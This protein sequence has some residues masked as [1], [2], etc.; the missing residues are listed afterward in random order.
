[1]NFAEQTTVTSN[2]GP[3]AIP[4]AF[5]QAERLLRPIS[6]SPGGWALWDL[7][8]SPFQVESDQIGARYENQVLRILRI[9]QGLDG[10]QNPEQ[11]KYRFNGTVRYDFTEGRLKGLQVG[12]TARYQDKVSGGYP[13]MLADD[14]VTVLPDIAN[15]W[16]GPDSIDG[17]LF[18]R[19]RKSLTDK[20]DWTIQLN[21]RNLY[22][23]NGSEDIPV[24]IN[25]DGTIAIIRVPV[26]QQYFLTNT[27]SF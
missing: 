5:E 17:D 14:G 23:S 24:S 21:A 10:T 13:N 27:F 22:R 7:R 1:L 16:F 4:L 2:T 3:V 9:Q 18:V 26:E 11:R 20:I 12:A 8:G 25:P 19:Y 15:A 6:T